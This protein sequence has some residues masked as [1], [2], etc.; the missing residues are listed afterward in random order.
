MYQKEPGIVEVETM[1]QKLKQK[2]I[3]L[4]QNY[5]GN[6]AKVKDL[7]NAL[8]SVDLNEDHQEKE[9]LHFVPFRLIKIEEKIRMNKSTIKN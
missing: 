2:L 6:N 4:V 7:L 9:P 5:F 1:K 8:Q 3:G